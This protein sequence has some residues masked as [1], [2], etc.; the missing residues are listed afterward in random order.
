MKKIGK[1]GR[2]VDA[3]SAA[4]DSR[5]I[6]NGE[7]IDRWQTVLLAT[8]VALLVAR[9]LVPE[10]PGSQA[11]YGAP[12]DVL[13][14]VLMCV[15]LLGQLR[16]GAVRLQFGVVDA[17]MFALV[18][19]YA[20]SALVAFYIG[21]PRP[22]INA[23]WDWVAIGVTLILV[24]QIVQRARDAR[25]MIV[26]MLGL[27]CGLS[28]TAVHQYFVTIPAD[29]RS[30]EAAKDSTES[31][32]EQ[33]GQWMPP[34]S[35]VRQQFENRLSSRLPAATFALS[36]SLAGFL[37]PWFVILFAIT[38]AARRR[39]LLVAGAISLAL[40]SACIYLTGSRS[41]GVAV[42]VGSFLVVISMARGMKISRTILRTGAAAL[43]A[44]FI[45]ALAI[46]FGTSAGRAALAA[47]NRSLAFRFEYWRATAAMI[48][49]YPWFGC[50]PGQ[51]QDYYATYKLPEA[52]EV[53]QDAHNWLLEIWATAGTPAAV[54]LVAVL[55]AAIVRAW[56]VDRRS[57]HDNEDLQVSIPDKVAVARTAPEAAIFGGMIGVA[58]GTAIA[59]L[60]GFPLARTHMVFIVTGIV[61][62][63][64]IWRGWVEEGQLPRRLPLIAVV[65][66][67]INLLAA[68]GIA[69]PGIAG[70][71]WLLVAIGLNSSDGFGDRSFIS[72]SRSRTT[73]FLESKVGRWTACV[74]LAA[75]L[76]AAIWTEYLPIMA[77]RLRLSIAD[78]AQ[79][80][81]RGDQLRAALEAAKTADPWSSE[82]AA[83]LAAQR[84]A[85][86][87][88]LPTPTQRQLLQEAD[89]AARQLAPRRSN[90]WAQS[91]DFAAA[92]HHNTG[93]VED[94]EAAAHYFERAI[95]L[96][97][98]HAELRSKAA[99]FWQSAGASDRAREAAAEA[100]RL[101]DLMRACGHT[102]RL[103]DPALRRETEKIAQTKN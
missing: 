47:A 98:S 27:A 29:L 55:G 81:G 102:D 8:P 78:A 45:A 1:R 35:S 28:A 48:R 88:A 41:G 66:L 83:R 19:C 31:L 65:A 46:G 7:P 32:Y 92:I 80:A 58:L 34:G 59:W 4:A 77:C 76:A 15:W 22:A 75:M 36:N 84:F 50:G 52:S 100:V 93:S 99:K 67:L 74:G 14:I 64:W 11:G 73:H 18:G 20:V 71:L 24:R 37:V 85:D 95:D 90:V 38:I 96:F 13:W 5:S 3:N 16:R 91:A 21:S 10:D 23:L 69:Y 82:A 40:L 61:G 72:S 39:S 17:L 49:D 6:D 56:R 94:R 97:P 62:S 103:L 89:A 53:V 30:Y 60:C 87:Q 54:L 68:G 63:W 43:V 79:A 9:P 51:F 33:T 42:L 57:G 2:A 12:F 26:V 44:I 86:Y 70:S 101:D 25:A